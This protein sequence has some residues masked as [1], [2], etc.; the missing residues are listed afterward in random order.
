MKRKDDDR[1]LQSGRLC[2]RISFNVK[3]VNQKL[4][5]YCAVLEQLVTMKEAI[6][7]DTGHPCDS[8]SNIQAMK[9]KDL[10][11][12][13]CWKNLKMYRSFSAQ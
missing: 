10:K 5:A 13:T 1:S 11:I 2:L 8:Q 7:A 9:S 12:F 6:N 4:L 3:Q